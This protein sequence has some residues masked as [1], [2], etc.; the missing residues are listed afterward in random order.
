MKGGGKK[1]KKKGSWRERKRESKVESLRMKKGEGWRKK[2]KE[3]ERKWR[4]VFN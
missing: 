3:E 1:V 2:W 4:K